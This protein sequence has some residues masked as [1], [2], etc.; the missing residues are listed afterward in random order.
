MG[1]SKSITK[2]KIELIA[3]LVQKLDIL[4]GLKLSTFFLCKLDC[5]QITNNITK[6]KKLYTN[7][8]N[9]KKKNVIHSHKLN[10]QAYL[11]F[12]RNDTIVHYLSNGN[13]GTFVTLMKAELSRLTYRVVFGGYLQLSS[14][15]ECQG[16][17]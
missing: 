13:L 10:Q 2:T 17:C 5:Q 16:T 14:I 8:Q 15:H 6:T 7:G 1:H 4:S 12:I 11:H 3:H 9:E